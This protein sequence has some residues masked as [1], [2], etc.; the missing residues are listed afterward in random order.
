MTYAKNEKKLF[1]NMLV[2]N[3]YSVA[4]IQFGGQY[5]ALTR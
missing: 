3:T 2:K 4:T 5:P 1:G